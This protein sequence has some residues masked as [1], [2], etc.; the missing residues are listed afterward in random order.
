M[1]KRNKKGYFLAR[2]EDEHVAVVHRG[3]G[4][5]HLQENLN[6]FRTLLGS[7]DLGMIFHDYL[8]HH[9]SHP[10]GNLEKLRLVSV[11]LSFL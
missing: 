8:L 6:I 1:K 7:F 2:V 5:V 11:R 3:P 9:R 4:H 10:P